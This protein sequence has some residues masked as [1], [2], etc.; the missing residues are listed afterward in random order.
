M[1]QACSFLVAATYRSMLCS[2]SALSMPSSE[3]SHN[4][5]RYGGAANGYWWSLGSDPS[6]RP[7]LYECR[8]ALPVSDICH[9]A[10]LSLPKYCRRAMACSQICCI[11][12]RSLTRAVIH[13]FNPYPGLIPACRRIMAHSDNRVATSPGYVLWAMRSAACLPLSRVLIESYMGSVHLH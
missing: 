7:P 11:L 3:L 6:L 2:V 10:P 4:R 12:S 1:I 13:F 9:A 5:C 8:G